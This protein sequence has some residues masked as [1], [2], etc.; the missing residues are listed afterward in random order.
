MGIATHALSFYG[1]AVECDTWSN[2]LYLYIANSGERRLD[3]MQRIN[4]EKA[5]YAFMA[6]LESG[7]YPL[8]RAKNDAENYSEVKE[9]RDTEAVQAFTK[10][11]IFQVIKELE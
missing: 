6:K 7:A 8:E 2:Q 11:M 1:Y 9:E 5:A 10:S 3:S 4:E